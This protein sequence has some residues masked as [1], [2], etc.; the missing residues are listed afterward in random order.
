M[1][2]CLSKITL[3]FAA[4]VIMFCTSSY[5]SGTCAVK[6]CYRSAV[7]GGS[8]CSN[9]ICS[10]YSCKNLAVDGG[11][12]SAH[13]KKTYAGSSSSSS[14]QAADK[15]CAVSGC[16][17][18]TI[19]GSAYCN[20]HKCKHSG[21]KNYGS[22]NGYCYSHVKKSYSGSSS[23][24][25]SPGKSYSYGSFGSSSSSAKQC[26]VVGCHNSRAAS[27]SY[28]SSH[29]MAELGIRNMSAYIRKMSLDGLCVQLDLK[30][31]RE[32]TEQV[33]RIG[34]NLNQY[35]KVAN[36]TGSIYAQ[37]IA[38]LREQFAVLCDMEGKIL[39]KLAAIR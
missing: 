6:G 26:I 14:D 13:Q 11:H 21:C 16:S 12:C 25:I 7:Y 36:A 29:K 19:G 2:S 27:S 1:K 37:D 9:H 30:D 38:Y 39:A 28:C 4:V 20:S 32:F 22:D 18:S 24:S 34:N 8:Y 31:I 17:R 10:K 35:A 33:S 15:T 5:A 23:G 3:V